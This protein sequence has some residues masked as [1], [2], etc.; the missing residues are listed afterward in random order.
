MRNTELVVGDLQ[1]F[2][3]QQREKSE[4]DQTQ[5]AEVVGR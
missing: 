5:T 1:N 4:Q 3:L 2:Q